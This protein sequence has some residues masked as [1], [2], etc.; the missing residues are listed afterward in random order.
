MELRKKPEKFRNENN[1]DKPKPIRLI[2][3][4]KHFYK[5]A[6]TMYTG[7]MTDRLKM[8]AVSGATSMKRKLIG[9]RVN[10]HKKFNGQGTMEDYTGNEKS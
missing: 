1:Q 9:S 4:C 5:R 10:K 3:C 7:W 8:W 2:C 6:N